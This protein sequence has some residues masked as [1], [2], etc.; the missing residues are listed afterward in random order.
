MMGEGEGHENPCAL[1]KVGNWQE[2]L[3]TKMEVGKERGNPHDIPL[4]GR[5]VVGGGFGGVVINKKGKQPNILK[6]GCPLWW[7][8][9]LV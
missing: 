9:M 8:V 3:Q 7:D 5:D 6:L 4:S 2:I 1:I